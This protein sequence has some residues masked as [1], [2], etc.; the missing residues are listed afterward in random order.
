MLELV[1]LPFCSVVFFFFLFGLHFLRLISDVY[2][3][4]CSLGSSRGFLTRTEICLCL[5]A[6]ICI[7]SCLTKLLLG[8]WAD[9]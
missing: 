8:V 7:D 5:G 2:S 1:K 4:C 3:F 9:G 6:L